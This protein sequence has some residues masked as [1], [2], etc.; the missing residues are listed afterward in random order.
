MIHHQF[1]AGLGSWSPP[2]K[3]H[4]THQLSNRA[5]KTGKIFPRLQ[6]SYKARPRNPQKTISVNKVFLQYLLCRSLE[7]GAPSDEISCQKS[8]KKK[9]WKQ[10][11]NKIEIS[12]LG[13]QHNFRSQNHTKIDKNPVPDHFMSILLLPWSS[14]VVPRCQK[15]S[16]G[17]PRDAKVVTQGAKMEAPSLQNGN[18]QKLVRD[19]C[20]SW[21]Q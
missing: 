18:R 13:G 12:R 6:K 3:I 4:Q 9:T 16:P 20:S 10:V 1:S 11:R 17:C 14:S 8:I 2:L 7:S 15:G 5:T 19:H 21:K